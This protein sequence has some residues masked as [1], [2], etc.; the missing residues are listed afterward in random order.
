VRL[1]ALS[2]SLL[3]LTGCGAPPRQT[4]SQPTQATVAPTQEAIVK[5]GYE[6]SVVDAAGKPVQD[7]VVTYSTKINE[8]AG[9]NGLTCSTN[10]AGICLV[11]VFVPRD[12]ALRFTARHSSIVSFKIAKDGFYG[13]S[14]TLLSAK[15]K[16]Y[17]SS[18]DL[19]KKKSTLLK[20][21]D[22]LSPEFLASTSDRELR[23]Q[24]LKFITAIRLQSLLTDA[25]VMTQSVKVENFKSRKYLRV[26]IESTAVFNTLKLNKYEIGKRLFDDSIRKIL[27]PLN[28]NVSNP[29]TFYGYDLLIIGKSK[30]FAQEYATPTKTEYRFLMPQE[31]VKKYKDKD[32]SGQQLLDASVLL[33]DDERIDMKLQ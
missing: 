17:T 14:G 21:A 25:D 12:P 18:D 29:K 8:G 10:A 19:V 24:S 9:N 1:I 26:G 6:F 11:E 16:T 5:H 28:D 27:N 31:A 3:L 2:A 15:S 30:S 7:A 22:Y 20:P 13:D 23:D 33:M 4:Y 32:I